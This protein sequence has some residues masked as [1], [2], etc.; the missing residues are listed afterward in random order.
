MAPAVS[1]PHRAGLWPD[2]RRS[3]QHFS[4][5]KRGCLPLGHCPLDGE[6]GAGVLS[7]QSLHESRA[8]ESSVA[9]TSV[10]C[11]LSPHGYFRKDVLSETFLFCSEERGS[12]VS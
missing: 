5:A 11:S 4:F 7:F 3:S 12:G 6:R 2:G 9:G 8:L 10:E 1:G